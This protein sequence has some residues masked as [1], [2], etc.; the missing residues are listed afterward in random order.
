MSVQE[1]LTLQSFL[2]KHTDYYLT[3]LDDTVILEVNCRNHRRFPT[4][5][6][7]EDIKLLGWANRLSSTDYTMCCCGCASFRKIIPIA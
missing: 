5:A 3:A 6:E 2:T 1:V 7:I 4:D